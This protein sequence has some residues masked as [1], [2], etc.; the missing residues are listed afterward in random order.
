MGAAS[1]G[2][3][4][5]PGLKMAYDLSMGKLY[6]SNVRRQFRYAFSV[7]S[8][9]DTPLSLLQYYCISCGS[10]SL[11]LDPIEVKHQVERIYY[12]S[13]PSW[14]T[15]SVTLIDARQS[16][17]QI[18]AAPLSALFN[19]WLSDFYGGYETSAVGQINLNLT[20]LK[21]KCYIDILGSHGE[22]EDRWTLEGCWPTQISPTSFNSSSSD[23]AQVELDL[24]YDRAFLRSGRSEELSAVADAFS[25]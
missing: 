5:L 18:T 19:D 23:P 3:L 1:A 12:P 14:S 4:L 11:T 20:M 17:T 6:T 9:P 13:R 25:N 8:D 10:P 2:P 16:G 24:R 21:R 22:L 7:E 15:V